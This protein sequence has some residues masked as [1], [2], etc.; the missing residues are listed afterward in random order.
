M[1]VRYGGTME[2]VRLNDGTVRWCD[3]SGTVKWWYG[4][5]VRWKWHC[6]MMVRWYSGGGSV[7]SGTVR[8]HGAIECW[9]GKLVRYSGA[10]SRLCCGMRCWCGTVF[11]RCV[12]KARGWDKMLVRYGDVAWCGMLVRRDVGREFMGILRCTVMAWWDVDTIPCGR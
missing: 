9:Y 2:V 12:G 11:L 4:T 6:Q 8:W 10:V 3:G 5:V 1:M 7:L